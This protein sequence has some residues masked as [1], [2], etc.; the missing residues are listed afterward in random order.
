MDIEIL[1]STDDCECAA[2]GDE[3]R[4]F[5]G[6]QFHPEVTDTPCGMKI[7][8][9]FIGICKC[10]LQWNSDTFLESIAEEIRKKAGSRNVFLLVSGGVD[11]TVAFSLL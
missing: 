4:H 10:K 1:G 6:L 3:K 5:Y 9:N 11:S 8:E 2:V 7:L